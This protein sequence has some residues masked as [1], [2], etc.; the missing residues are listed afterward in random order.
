[1]DPYVKVTL[2]TPH[3]PDPDTGKDHTEVKQTKPALEAGMHPI[4]SKKR[5]RSVLRLPFS[6]PPKLSKEE[7]EKAEHAAWLLARS[8][9][10]RHKGVV[11]FDFVSDHDW[12]Q[13]C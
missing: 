5:H 1:M 10:E 8:L 9:C 12:Y 4:W 3:E 13:N 6:A 2:E 11:D 7:K